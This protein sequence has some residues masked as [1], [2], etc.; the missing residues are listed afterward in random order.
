MSNRE[1]ATGVFR[2]WG[3]MWSIY[4]LIGVPQLLNALL[5][6]NSA[7]SDKATESYYL[8]SQTIALGC[9]IIVLIFLVRKAEWLARLVFPVEKEMGLS[10]NA[11]DLRT[12]LFSVV[13]LYF[14]LDGARRGLGSAYQLVARPRG[15]SQNAAGYLWER[16]PEN[17]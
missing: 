11:A 8:S 9:E 5:R 2:A 4:L 14:V 16:D 7:W 13:G 1:V 17:L 15:G 10:F 12:V 6:H 3:V